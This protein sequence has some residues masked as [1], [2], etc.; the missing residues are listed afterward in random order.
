MCLIAF[1]IDAS[2]RWPLVIA[3]NRDEFLDRPTLPL[4]SWKTASGQTIVSGR[5][6]RAGGTWM[7]ATPEG[8]IAFVTNVREAQPVEAP[9]SRGELVT[10]WLEGRNDV[11]GFAAALEAEHSAYAGFN[12]VIG[13][14]KRKAWMWM[15]NRTSAA[16]PGWRAQILTPGIY[17]LSNAALDSPWPK[18]VSLKHALASALTESGEQQA[19]TEPLWKA[20]TNRQRVSSD[21]PLPKTGLA[22][23]LEQALS[24]AFVDLPERAYRT[25]SS[26]VLLLSRKSNSDPKSLIFQIEERT[27]FRENLNNSVPK[28][29][30]FIANL[31]SFELCLP[32]K[33]QICKSEQA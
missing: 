10:R 18:T 20:L 5:D 15:T 4:T 27:Y 26:T 14:V 13:D 8:R 3:A 19:L 17:G 11:A 16:S 25:R 12:L 1:A 7:G 30:E 21:D 6:V 23:A 24:S 31:N 28:K 9:R 2:A 33:H 32:F 22:P 29:I